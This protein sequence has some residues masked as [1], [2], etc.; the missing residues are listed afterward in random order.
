M[1]NFEE[2]TK[3]LNFNKIDGGGRAGSDAESP[4]DENAHFLK[5]KKKNSGCFD[6]CTPV[7]S[8]ST[9]QSLCERKEASCL[10]SVES[11]RS[12][13]DDLSNLVQETFD[14]PSSG[15]LIESVLLFES[16]FQLHASDFGSH[17]FLCKL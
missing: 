10:T 12:G 4:C 8:L 2:G 14:V 6:D 9:T 5:K 17:R 11:A 16:L 1:A 13:R 15:G 3:C 7:V